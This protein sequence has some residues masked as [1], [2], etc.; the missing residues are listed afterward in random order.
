L[1]DRLKTHPWKVKGPGDE[2]DAIC[3]RCKEETIHRVVALVEER[4]HQVI[5]TRC[6]SQHRYR[7]TLA[8]KTQKV[9]LPSSRQA[10]V[11]SKVAAAKCA[12]PAAP[13]DEW[14]QLK[15]RAENKEPLAYDM[16]GSYH[17][18]QA[19]EHPIFGRGFVRR[20]QSRDKVEVVFQRHVKILVMNRG[21]DA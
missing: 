15:E 18:N 21:K 1:A 19:I 9:P 20:V 13:L 2:I 3:R 11:L 6:G 5:C 10:K 12:E 4:V 8:A 14:L 16:A 17:E 7:T